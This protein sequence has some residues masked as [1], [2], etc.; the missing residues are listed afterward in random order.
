MIGYTTVGTHDLNKA[1]AFYGELLAGLG[2]KPLVDIGRL[3][4]FGTSMKQ[5]MFGVCLPYDQQQACVGNGCM[6]ALVAG[7]RAK[8]D[9]LHAKALSLGGSD[10]GAPGERMPGFYIGYFRD[11][12]G[13]KLAFFHAG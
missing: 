5:P 8:V 9:E 3:T 13:N 11:P 12:D 4:L 10:E 1:K 6:T 7:S 2:A